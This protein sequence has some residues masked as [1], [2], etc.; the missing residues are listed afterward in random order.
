MIE[1]KKV[2]LNNTF[3]KGEHWRVYDKVRKITRYYKVA[4]RGKTKSKVDSL[5]LFNKSV[6]KRESKGK[7]KTKDDLIGTR[8]I[9]HFRADYRPGTNKHFNLEDSYIRKKVPL[10]KTRDQ[11][12]QELETLFLETFSQQIGEALSL[13]LVTSGLETGV[14]GA[15][16]VVIRYKHRR[17]DF[18]VIRVPLKTA[19]EDL[20]KMKAF[21]SNT[22]KYMRFRN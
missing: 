3:R 8:A 21:F 2:N 7:T 10:W 9:L 14:S 18:Q 16:E 12:F 11:I 5:N 15:E 19:E 6:Q 17:N 1:I 13:E 22:G 4:S 20:Q